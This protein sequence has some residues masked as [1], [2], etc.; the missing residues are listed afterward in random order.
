MPLY[1][2][3][4][5]AT[6]RQYTSA[7]TASEIT[8]YPAL[9]PDVTVNGQLTEKTSQQVFAEWGLEVDF[10]AVFLCDLTDADDI[11]VGYL[12]I[13]NSREYYV[14]AGPKRMDA[15]PITAHAMYLLNRTDE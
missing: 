13:V 8:S 4:H 10:P 5:S 2:K 3:P 15:E 9:T 12:I 14:Q 11:Q 7:T 6:V 1:Y